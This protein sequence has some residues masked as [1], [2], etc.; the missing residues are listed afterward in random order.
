MNGE[1]KNT[2]EVL[3]KGGVILYP[4]DTIWGLGCDATNEKAVQKIFEIKRREESKSLIVLVADETR[5]NRYVKEVPPVVW[6]LIEVSEKPLTIV[7]PGVRGLALNVTAADKS[8]AIRI[9]KDEF[10]KKL[11][12]QF[13]KPIVSTSANIS[14]EKTP[15]NFSEISDEVKNKA[16]Y[17]VPLRQNEMAKGQASSI[18]KFS[19]KGEIV[20]IRR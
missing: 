17:I 19:E 10:C 14:G 2:V 3:N 5:L 12:F 8:A 13:K 11:L 16:D 1:I 6:E 7:Y 18:I 15:S 9:P 20:I 4:T